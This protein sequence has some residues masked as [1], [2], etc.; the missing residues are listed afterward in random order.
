M[1]MRF[2]APVDEGRSHRC[3]PSFGSL[4]AVGPKSNRRAA[5][6]NHSVVHGLP[7]SKRRWNLLPATHVFRDEQEWLRGGLGA[8]SQ[9]V[10]R[11]NL[12]APHRAALRP[13]GSPGSPGSRSPGRRRAGP[14]ISSTIQYQLPIVSTATE[15]PAHTVQE[16]PA[17]RRAQSGHPGNAPAGLTAGSGA[18]RE[19]GFA[20]PRIHTETREAKRLP[21]PRVRR[22]RAEPL[23][24]DAAP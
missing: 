23:S 11:R 1:P 9:R 5:R 12:R 14:G 20:R 6:M 21:G 3:R 19:S 4:E 7:R 18:G 16:T 22:E 15:I 8:R 24:A 17:V 10:P 2:S 13:D